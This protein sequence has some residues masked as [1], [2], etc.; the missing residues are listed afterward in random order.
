MG[1]Y[2]LKY[3]IDKVLVENTTKLV[4]LKIKTTAEILKYLEEI[5]RR[6]LFAD[7][8]HPSMIQFCIKELK[9]S[10]GSAYRR[11]QSARLLRQVPEILPL[12]SSG[13]LSVTNTAKASDF[14][15]AEKISDH[16]A[17]KDIIRGLLGKTTSEAEAKLLSISSPNSNF[18]R[19]NILRKATPNDWDL[20][21]TISNELKEKLIHIKNIKSHSVKNFEDLIYFLAD[22]TL[23]EIS[24]DK[25]PRK[26]EAKSRCATLAQKNAGHRCE[27][28]NQ[29]SGQRC[30]GPSFLQ[31]DHIHSY[32]YGGKTSLFNMRILCSAHNQMRA[33]FRMN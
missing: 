19:K 28:I 24:K 22:T 11:L 13:Q 30:Q 2:S 26:L 7:Y 32:A 3:L 6:K 25:N 9:Y 10:E 27:H 20:N 18:R 15:K 31:A 1:V 14:F 5:E 12:I 8:G 4:M 33:T 29:K 16:D 17:K 23:K 21:V